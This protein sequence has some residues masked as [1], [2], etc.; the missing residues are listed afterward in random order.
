MYGD[1]QV[2]LKVP[3]VA[4]LYQRMTPKSLITTRWSGQF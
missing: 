4:K 2:F 3:N 1:L